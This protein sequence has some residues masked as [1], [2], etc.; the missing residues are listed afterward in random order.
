MQS[1]IYDLENDTL[2]LNAGFPLKD[3]RIKAIDSI[4]LFFETNHD[5]KILP[6]AVFRYMRR[7][8]WDRTYQRN[9]TTI[10]QLKN[11]G[12]MRLIRKKIVADSI[13]AYDWKWQRNEYWR[14]AYITYQQKMEDLTNQIFNANDLVS[15]YKYRIQPTFS[16]NPTITDTM[17]I[18]INP[19]PLNEYLNLL[20]RQKINTSQDKRAYQTTE[21]SAERL[22]ELIKKEYHLE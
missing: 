14:E 6:G 22:I 1:L 17:T 4:F 20:Y 16:L 8:T 3:Q 19:V 21:K 13:A 2:N 11:A 5:V 7:S 9:S 10:D 18:R 12:G 15:K